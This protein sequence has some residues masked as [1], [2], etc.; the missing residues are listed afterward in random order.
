VQSRRNRSI[1]S[2]PS[3]TRVAISVAVGF[4]VFVSLLPPESA[5]GDG[6]PDVALDDLL[7]LPSTLDLEPAARGRFT[8][9]EWRERFDEARAK[10]AE[11][12]AKLAE[13]QAKIAEAAGDANAW[14]V[15]A[16]G[17]GAVDSG[18]GPDGPLDYG[19]ANEMRRSREEVVRSER[20]L[21]EL[22]I[23]ANLAAVPENWR[24]TVTDHAED[25]AQAP[26]S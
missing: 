14:K 3:A 2:A 8:K 5:A 7:Q 17:L 15:A 11:A 13:S 6:S 26:P 12:K 25:S 18:P 19:L 9:A 21:T 24:G 16:P 4:A 22:E 10:V 20:K 23:E 1:R